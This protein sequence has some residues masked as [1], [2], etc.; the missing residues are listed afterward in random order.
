MNTKTIR[1]YR[2][3]SLRKL[4][5]KIHHFF[6]WLLDRPN[7]CPL[8]DG[9][10]NN[11]CDYPELR[12]KYHGYRLCPRGKPCFL[13]KPEYTAERERINDERLN[14]TCCGTRT[15]PSLVKKGN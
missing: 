1:I 2:F 14:L 5:S 12:E 8:M 10:K 13:R 15:A 3:P 11:K 6:D 4:S 7:V 9:L